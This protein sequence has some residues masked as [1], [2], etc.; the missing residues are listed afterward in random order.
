MVGTH[1][2][3]NR[4]SICSLKLTADQIIEQM[5][6]IKFDRCCVPALEAV[7]LELDQQ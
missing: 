3:Q 6:T 5:M 4:N 2:E 7:I 1:N